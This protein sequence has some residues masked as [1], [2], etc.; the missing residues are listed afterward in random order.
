MSEPSVTGQMLA[1]YPADLGGVDRE[2][3]RACIERCFECAQ[4][5]TACADACLAEDGV[6][7][8][9]RCIRTNLDCADICET[10]GRML[11]RHTGDDPDL[12]WATLD[13]CAAACAICA[14]EC[15]RHAD[16]HEYCRVCE[17]VCRQCAEVCRGLIGSVGH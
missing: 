6:M 4:A 1:T 12:T 2:R 15:E 10:T 13:A 3:L 14:D 7:A 9:T 11:S 8:L 5:C 17:Q 16:R